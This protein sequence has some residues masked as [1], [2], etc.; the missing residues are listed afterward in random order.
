[1]RDRGGVSGFLATLYLGT[2]YA[3]VDS[4]MTPCSSSS[5]IKK[6]IQMS[7][8]HFKNILSTD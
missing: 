6:F 5:Q 2:L 7:L 4:V 8:F 3:C 1:M